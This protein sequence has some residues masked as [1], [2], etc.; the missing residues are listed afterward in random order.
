MALETFPRLAVRLRSSFPD[1]KISLEPKGEGI[2][3]RFRNF[4]AWDVVVSLARGAS[5]DNFHTIVSSVS[6][7]YDSLQDLPEEDFL[8]FIAAENLGLRGATLIAD[9]SDGQRL[10]RVRSTFLAQKGR[11]R[12]EAENLAIDILSLLRYCRLLEDRINHSTPGDVFSYELYFA[13]YLSKGLGR[14]RFINYARSI[15]D[16]STERVFGQFSDMLLKDYSYPVQIQS[17]NKALITPPDSSLEIHLR[18]PEEIPMLICQATLAAF[19]WDIGKTFALVSKLNEVNQ[20]GHFEVNADGFH[21]SFSAWKHLTNDLRY[22]SLDKLIQSVPAAEK[23]LQKT[24]REMDIRA[25]RPKYTE[26]RLA[27][28]YDDDSLEALLRSAI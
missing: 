14:N 20:V 28:Y 8:K 16:G 3:V 18:I 2:R 21:V 11:T 4:P 25:S 24:L 27:P 15:F 26:P 1:Q 6:L 19:E 23:L 5:T 13:T 10:I 22:Y 7:R 12:D 17:R 9:R